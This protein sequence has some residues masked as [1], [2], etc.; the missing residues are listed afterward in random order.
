MDGSVFDA[1]HVIC[2]VS[3]GV[4]KERYLGLFNPPL[5]QNKVDAIEGLSIGVVDKIYLEFDKPFWEEGWGGFSLLWKSEELKSIREDTQFSWLEDVFGFYTVDFQ[6]NI[7]CGWISG[8]KARQME[9]L[10]VDDVKRGAMFL[11]RTFLKSYDIPEPK[12]V[13]RLEQAYSNGMIILFYPQIVFFRSTWYSNPHFRGSYTFYSLKSDSLN[14]TTTQLSQPI[15]DAV[16]LPV[17][18]F[19]GEAT[20]QHYY[21]TVHGAVESGWREAKRL[22]D[23]YK[24]V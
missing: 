5:P 17:L 11:L 13:E 4:L 1:D 21:S 14:V 20:N 3:L 22:I 24:N 18:Q 15:N 2:T 16:G 19:A 6:P 10:P 8:A 12:A 9:Q 7:L 23:T